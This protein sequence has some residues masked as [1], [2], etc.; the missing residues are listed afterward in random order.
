MRSACLMQDRKWPPPHFPPV[1]DVQTAA[2]LICFSEVQLIRSWSLLS[3]ASLSI[4]QPPK[5]SL[6][7]HYM[8]GKNEAGM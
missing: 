4:I 1:F 3:V 5:S 7:R 6:L 2:G 8:T